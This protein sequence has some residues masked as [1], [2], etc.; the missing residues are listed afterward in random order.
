MRTLPIAL[1]GTTLL[2][3]LG[4]HHNDAGEVGRTS[5]GGDMSTRADMRTSPEID[6][7][8]LPADM[9]TGADMSAPPAFIRIAH[10]SPDKPPIDVCLAPLGSTQFSGPLLKAAGVAPTGLAYAQVTKYLAVSAGRY[11]LRVID[12]GDT[13]CAHSLFEATNLPA[14][15]SG[16]SF[17]IVG[18]G[19]IPPNGGNPTSFTVVGYAD[20]SAGSANAVALRFIH[21]APDVP[22]IDF[23]TGSGSNFAALFSNVSYQHVGTSSSPA[24]DANGYA[25]VTP[26]S[27]AG[28]LSLRVSSNGIDALTVTNSVALPAGT[29]VTVFAIGDFSGTPQPLQT[30]I[31][32]DNVAPAGALSACTA[33]P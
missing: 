17:T 16:D 32:A 5:I 1:L 13:T 4:C 9:S 33:L 25:S 30:L 28:T 21:A 10:L 11:D 31:C 12:G 24:T 19:F 8:T 6:M 29:V 3:P 23:G 22:A 2:A 27:L 15:T 26:A 18:T 20:D 14:F 7:S